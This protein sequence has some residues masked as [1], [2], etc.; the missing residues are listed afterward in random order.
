MEQ[1]PNRKRPG[2]SQ[3]PLAQDG[4][5]DKVKN[6]LGQILSMRKTLTDRYGESDYARLLWY[7]HLVEHLVA[8]YGEDEELH[9]EA[10]E[11]VEWLRALNNTSARPA[12]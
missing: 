8:A 5:S 11:E 12:T 9:D 4:P 2:Q 6:E 10:H 7:E 1:S 3:V